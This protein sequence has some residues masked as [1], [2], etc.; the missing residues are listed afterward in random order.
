[1]HSINNTIEKLKNRIA[2]LYS[3]YKDR[4]LTLEEYHDMKE[5]F[6]KDRDELENEALRIENQICKLESSG[7]TFIEPV[8]KYIQFKDYFTLD[9]NFIYLN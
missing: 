3:D 2:G 1:M 8:Q 4:I 5:R 7:D 9:R 6:S